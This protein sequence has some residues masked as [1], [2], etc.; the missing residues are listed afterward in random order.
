M[1]VS[2][3]YAYV[4]CQASATNSTYAGLAKTFKW[5]GGGTVFITDVKVT[6]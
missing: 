5:V 3:D 2:P 6:D 1:P 4:S